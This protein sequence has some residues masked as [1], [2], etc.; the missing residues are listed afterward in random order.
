VSSR[1]TSLVNANCSPPLVL[2]LN[3]AG[4]DAVHVAD[5]GMSRAT[6]TVR[7]LRSPIVM[8]G[9]SSGRTPTSAH[10]WRGPPATP[11]S[12]AAAVGEPA[13]NRAAG[14]IASVEPASGAGR[15]RRRIGHRGRR[16]AHPHSFPTHL[17]R[18]GETP[19]VVNSW[20]L[21]G[22]ASSSRSAPNRDSICSLAP[23]VESPD[24]DVGL[25]AKVRMGLS[26]RNHLAEVR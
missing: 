4:H 12:V 2:G 1:V 26:K 24:G 8:T 21:R 7:F 25:A 15:T 10:C 6:L 23:R 22:P 17:L 3:E 9:W 16:R 14:S 13:P 18:D 5:L 19:G 20:C 11:F